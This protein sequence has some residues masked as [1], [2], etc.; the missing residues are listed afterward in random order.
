MKKNDKVVNKMYYVPDG[1]DKCGFY[2]CTRCQ[3]RFLDVRIVPK[4]V[5][6]ECG[7]EPDMEIGPGEPMP[8]AEEN[9]VL[10]KIL[11]G[12]DVERYDRLLS[13]A[14]TGGDFEWL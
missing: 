14:V 12:E 3:A 7:E 6:P 5:C 1:T 9:A 8:E 2:E 4:M 10:Q 11:E 13:L